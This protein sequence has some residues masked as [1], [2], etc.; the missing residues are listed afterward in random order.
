MLPSWKIWRALRE[1]PITGHHIYK[2]V[3]SVPIWPPH[4]RIDARILWGLGLL[5][6]AA[7][8]L[9]YGLIS[10]L[11]ALFVV[12]AVGIFVVL[13]LPALLPPLAVLAGTLWAALIS[14]WVVRESRGHTYDLLCAAPD[15]ALGANWVIASGCLHRGDVLAGLRLGVLTALLLGGLFFGLLLMVAVFL[16]VRSAAPDTLV[17]ALRTLLDLG[18]LIVVFYLH[19]IQSVALSALVGISAAG[20]FGSRGDTPWLAA[21]L[22]LA[23]QAISAAVFALFHTTVAPL[24]QALTPDHWLAYVSV[25]LVYVGVFLL[26]REGALLLLLSLISDRLN[27]S[28]VE[29]ERFLRLLGE[30]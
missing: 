3:A 9:S 5:A 25:P 14:S 11:L 27:A 16:I 24:A 2:R 4:W 29:R 7:L 23:V 10:L 17:T 26:L 20:L 1:P 28:A 21:A 19:F 18:A 12:P 22:Y 8:V 15:G 30:A 6:L 13:V